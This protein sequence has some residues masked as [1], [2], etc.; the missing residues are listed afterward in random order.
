MSKANGPMKCCW[1]TELDTLLGTFYA[2]LRGALQPFQA[3][4]ISF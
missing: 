4:T 2:T 1:R 3:T